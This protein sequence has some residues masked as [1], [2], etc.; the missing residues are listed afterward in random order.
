MFN[1]VVHTPVLQLSKRGYTAYMTPAQA[2]ADLIAHISRSIVRND[3][4]IAVTFDTVPSK[5]EG[6]DDEL[7][8]TVQC[9][10]ADAPF[11]I[12]K[13]GTTA[14]SIRAIAW[15]VSN[16]LKLPKVQVHFNVPELPQAPI[17]PSEA[18]AS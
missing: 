18:V 11:L 8:F 7:H 1:P 17:N 14:G 2:L 15:S 12:G 3:D 16:K 9:D 5:V 13:K 4:A 6:G 10:P